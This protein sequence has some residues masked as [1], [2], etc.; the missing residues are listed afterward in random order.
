MLGRPIRV[1]CRERYQAG[2]DPEER[3]S[4][5]H[6]GTWLRNRQSLDPDVRGSYLNSRR[7]VKE[8]PDEI[9]CAREADNAS[10]AH[11]KVK[12]LLNLQ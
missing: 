6:D 3:N 2:E 8:D 10:E 12:E 4:L 1:T 7:S 9:C 11:E 5:D